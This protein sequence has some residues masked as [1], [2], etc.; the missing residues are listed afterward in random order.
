MEVSK[1]DGNMYFTIL[2]TMPHNMLK[3]K[4]ICCADVFQFP[5]GL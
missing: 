5:L 4:I 1:V 2:K 3:I